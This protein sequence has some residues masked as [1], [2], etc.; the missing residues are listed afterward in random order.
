[1]TAEFAGTLRERISIERPVSERTAA[2]LRLVDWE[3]FLRCRAAIQ[4]EG[5]GA[6]SEAMAL[7][8]MPRFRVTMRRREGVMIDHRVLWRGRI[9]AVR[10]VIDDP[11]L[12][13]RLVLRCEET[14][15]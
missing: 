1:M 4:P 7:S 9:L 10:Q 15:L 2:G 8:A 3:P 13:D 11:R 12:P 5:T 14:R 6:E